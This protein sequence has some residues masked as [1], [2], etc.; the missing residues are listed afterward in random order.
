MSEFQ[1]DYTSRDFAALRSDLLALIAL[2]TER[3][4]DPTDY[5][6]LGNVLVETFAY[7]GDIM[8]YYID[9]VANETTI[10]TAVKDSTLLGFANL[11]GFKP[12]GPTPAEVRI[13][14]KNISDKTFD[15]PVGT[16]VMAPLTYGP[17]SEVYFET[18]S[19]ASAVEPDQEI[20]IYAREG[21]TVNTDRPDLID[22]TYNKALPSNLGTS[23][24]STGQS[25]NIL[26]QGVVDNSLTVYVGQGV[27]FAPWEYVDNLVEHGPDELV[28]TTRQNSNSTLTVL[29]GDGING[30]I[31]P[32][33]QLISATYRVSA[34]LSGN[35]IAGAVTEVSFIPGNID[36]EAISYL[37][38]TNPNA[39]Y[40]GANADSTTQLRKKI[41]A[42]ISARRRAVTLSDYEY[43]ALLVS[44][45]GRAKA[46]AAVYSSVILYVQP[47]N[48][49]SITP[50]R[51]SGQPTVAWQELAVEVE[52]YMAD[53]LSVGV[54]LTVLPPTYIPVY[55]SMDI[56]L[57][58]AYKRSV[59]SLALYKAFL[60]SNGLFA[61]N[62][63]DFG[64]K[65]AYSTVVATAAAVPGVAAVTVTK[66][67]TDNGSSIGTLSLSDNEVP[68]LLSANLLVTPTGGIN[69]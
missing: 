49:G 7:M 12:S 13:L 8:S 11:Y 69:L 24:G 19:P 56:E 16:Q 2:R 38:A 41:K 22:S 60:G 55:L 57:E 67:N 14:F 10:D 65:V 18:T 64:R 42:A 1:I 40:G 46:A 25:F 44:K 26:D 36:P 58:P 35:I 62:N 33:G 54:S 39:A 23:D 3:E 27:A 21:K 47:Q 34:G 45:V 61:Y 15:I 31:P 51:L 59:V 17:Y 9:R 4:W 63:N 29:F 20:Q 50:G 43:L 53:K 68:Y 37:T 6:D 52:N 48:D 30:L 32:S 66:L 28:F 5:S